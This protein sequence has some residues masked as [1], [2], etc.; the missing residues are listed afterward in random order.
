MWNAGLS[1]QV[2]EIRHLG[3]INGRMT[4]FLDTEMLGFLDTEAH[5]NRNGAS[6]DRMKK[7]RPRMMTQAI[8]LR[9]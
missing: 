8:R 4:M 3:A 2:S 6:V 1:A 5:F 9:I 7:I